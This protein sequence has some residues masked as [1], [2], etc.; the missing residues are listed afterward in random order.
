MKGAPEDWEE[1]IVGFLWERR[2]ELF[3]QGLIRSRYKDTLGLWVT[4]WRWKWLW[5][6]R[7]RLLREGKEQASENQGKQE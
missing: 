2:L 3:L 5:H 7:R 4:L 6:V 1:D